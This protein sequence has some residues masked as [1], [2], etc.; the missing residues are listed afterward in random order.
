MRF[1]LWLYHAWVKFSTAV[2]KVLAPVYVEYM[3]ARALAKAE[4]FLQKF[5][6]T[7]WY[8]DRHI[9]DQKRKPDPNPKCKHTKGGT[10]P[11][12]G[13]FRDYNVACHRFT[14]GRIKI[15]CLYSCGFV[16]WGGDAN[17]TEAV[18]MMESSTNTQTASET[19]W[20]RG[21]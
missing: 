1:K 11:S 3:N 8:H 21:K 20:K 4:K 17:W 9:S 10:L 12:P 5:R 7:Q 14:D 18:R 6:S 13:G 2:N 16:S 19:A 15:W